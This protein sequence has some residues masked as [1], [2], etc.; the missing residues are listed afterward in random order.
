MPGISPIIR[1]A[2]RAAYILGIPPQAFREQAKR[3]KKSYSRVVRGGGKRTDEFYPYK[4]AED[5]HVPIEMFE[6]RDGEYEKRSVHG[7]CA[8]R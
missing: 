3:E 1:S 7:Q 4:A 5:L 8:R 2:E 6:S